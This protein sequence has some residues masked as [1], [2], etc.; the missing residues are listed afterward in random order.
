MREPNTFPIP[1]SAE[2]CPYIGLHDDPG[3]SLAYCSSWNYCYH[4]RPPASVL[5][6]H[7]GTACLNREYSHCP[8]Y[9]SSG[10]KQLP[11]NLRGMTRVHL[12]K[13]ESVKKIAALIL[14]VLLLVSVVLIILSSRA[15][16]FP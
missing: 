9:L 14:F 13:H 10:S 7:Q 4:A 5:E 15:L 16:L 12:P 3:T 2:H 8:V 6:S 11:S 1:A